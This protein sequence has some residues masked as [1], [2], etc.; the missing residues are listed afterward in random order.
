MCARGCEREPQ[1]PNS[2]SKHKLGGRVA[3]SKIGGGPFG[4]SMA[5]KTNADNRQMP[6]PARS[7]IKLLSDSPWPRPRW[8]GRSPGSRPRIMTRLQSG[9]ADFFP[10]HA[11]E[12]SG[13]AS[14]FSKSPKR[15]ADR[16][17][18]RACSLFEPPFVLPRGNLRER[19]AVSRLSPRAWW[20]EPRQPC[21]CG[22]N[23]CRWQAGQIS[24]SKIGP[25][26]SIFFRES[27]KRPDLVSVVY[28]P[29][30]RGA[31]S[32]ASRV[33]GGRHPCHAR[34]GSSVSMRCKN[35]SKG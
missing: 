13:R 3:A 10:R 33:A 11:V 5:V 31:L 30:G 22:C 23:H 4:T 14:Q 1:C 25:S 26:S 32:A 9:S 29:T 28:L 6:W 7:K 16:C 17:L 20:V 15:W 2:V 34:V 12:A 18:S 19:G 21:S 27:S 8:S 35:V 24:L